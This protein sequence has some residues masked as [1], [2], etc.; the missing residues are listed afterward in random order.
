MEKKSDEDC[1]EKIWETRTP[2]CILLDNHL[3]RNALLALTCTLLNRQDEKGMIV[4]FLFEESRFT[5]H[6]H[7]HDHRSSFTDHDHDHDN[8]HNRAE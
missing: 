6:D 2:T 1:H 5:D 7:D 8:D 3:A 4:D